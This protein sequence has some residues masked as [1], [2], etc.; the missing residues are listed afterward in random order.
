[1]IIIIKINL[2]FSKNI[3]AQTKIFKNPNFL[4]VMNYFL[5]IFYRK[6]FEIKKEKMEY[7]LFK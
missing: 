2:F 4:Q 3:E 7:S 6:I 5:K 1:M